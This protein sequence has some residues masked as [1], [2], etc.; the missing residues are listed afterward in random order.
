MP[1]LTGPALIPM[2]IWTTPWGELA[3]KSMSN[4]L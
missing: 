3:S 4:G 2:A 1:T